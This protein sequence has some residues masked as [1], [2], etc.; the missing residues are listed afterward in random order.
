M[1]VTLKKDAFLM[2]V[3][4]GGQTYFRHAPRGKDEI[5]QDT[6]LTDKECL[7]L[8]KDLIN[9]V[10]LSKPQTDDDPV[11]YTKNGEPLFMSDLKDI[12]EF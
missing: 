2:V 9:H 1:N 10:G 3:H 7:R 5:I 12:G 11:G 8:A 4:Y 6:P